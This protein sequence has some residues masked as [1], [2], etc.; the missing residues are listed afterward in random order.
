MMTTGDY[1]RWREE[2]HRADHMGFEIQK[3]QN[4]WS[5]VIP[6]KVFEYIDA[7][8]LNRR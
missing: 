6:M 5:G 8:P 7:R 2:S 4:K 3:N 1:P